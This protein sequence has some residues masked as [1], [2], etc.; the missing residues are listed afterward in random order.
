VRGGEKKDGRD[1]ITNVLKFFELS[2]EYVCPLRNEATQAVA[3]ENNLRL[4]TFSMLWGVPEFK[5]GTHTIFSRYCRA[6][7]QPTQQ[8]LGEIMYIQ[9]AL[10]IPIRVITKYVYS[11][12][13]EVMITG[14]PFLGPK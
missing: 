5:V 10:L 13:S 6:I 8:I 9:Y 3:N 1:A 12:I 2:R 7:L 11:H 4:H 14:Q